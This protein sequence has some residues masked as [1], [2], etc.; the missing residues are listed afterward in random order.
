MT[1]GIGHAGPGADRLDL[2]GRR[3]D[4]G[5]RP[6]GVHAFSVRALVLAAITRRGL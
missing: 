2:H 1:Q 4:K 6:V 5:R 3:G